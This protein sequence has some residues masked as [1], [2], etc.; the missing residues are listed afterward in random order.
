MESKLTM[1]VLSLFAAVSTC[2]PVSAPL[3]GDEGH[4]PSRPHYPASHVAWLPAGCAQRETLEGGW[5][6]KKEAPGASPTVPTCVN[7]SSSSG[8]VYSVAAQEASV[9]LVSFR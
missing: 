4:G 5:W 8:R 7:A 3:W 1:Q 6:S 9:V 2:W